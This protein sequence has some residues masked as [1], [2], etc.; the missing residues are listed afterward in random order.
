MPRKK[1]DPNLEAALSLVKS[2]KK[3][4]HK[5]RSL[6]GS[7]NK[8]TMLRT[9]LYDAAAAFTLWSDSNASDNYALM[10]F[11]SGNLEEAAD[12]WSMR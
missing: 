4:R 10:R 3:L 6:M 12:A 11:I 5:A 2:S 9:Q 1:K 8:N 7:E